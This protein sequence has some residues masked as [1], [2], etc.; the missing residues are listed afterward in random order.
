MDNRLKLKDVLKAS[1]LKDNNKAQDKVR[2]SGYIIDNELSNEQSK[3][4]YNPEQNKLLVAFRGSKTL[5]DWFETDPMLAIG[6]IRSTKRYKDSKEHL[7]KSKR[8][9]NTDKA[10]I[11]GHSLG[12]GIGSS[13]ADKN[14]TIYSYNKGSAIFGNST[15]N[16]PNERSY[17]QVGDIISLFDNKPIVQRNRN[18]FLD[19]VISP[20]SLVGSFRSHNLDNLD[21]NPTFIE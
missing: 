4:F 8:K 11:A 13:V 12:S 18:A 6:Q 5:E 9:Y 17:T 19:Y 3:T 14:D 1:Y 20:Y 7:E 2:Y 16:K 21:S 10:I 15:K